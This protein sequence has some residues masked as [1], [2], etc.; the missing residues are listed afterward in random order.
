MRGGSAPQTVEAGT[1]VRVG[2][3]SAVD[4]G[5][6]PGREYSYALFTRRKG[7]WAGPV[8]LT[9]GT[10]SKPGAAVAVAAYATPAST[11]IVHAG[12]Q[13]VPHLIDGI[14]TVTLPSGQ[15]TPV[16]GT[17]FVLPIST[18]LSGGFLGTVTS[19]SANGRAVT[20]TPAG[21]ADVFTQYDLN[22][23]LP[24]SDPQLAVP[25]SEI[26]NGRSGRASS[27]SRG[28]SRKGD[29][30]SKF[31]LNPSL[32]FGGSKLA[33]SLL[34]KR[35]GGIPKGAKFSFN[36]SAK[37]SIAPVISTESTSA[38]KCHL[39]FRKM[40]WN[41][42]THPVPMSMVF[43]PG[44]QIDIDGK[45]GIDGVD[46][47]MTLK[48][49]ADGTFGSSNSFKAQRPSV[50]AAVDRSLAANSAGTIS[51]TL[52]GE[53]TVGPGAG[54][55]AAGVIAGVSGQLKPVIA[56]F[57]ITAATSG[58]GA[59][60]AT[61][62]GGEASLRLIAK[63]WLG[64]FSRSRSFRLHTEPWDYTH[65]TYLYLPAGCE[66]EGDSS[67]TG[68]RGGTGRRSRSSGPDPGAELKQVRRRDPRVRDPP[69][70]QQLAQMPG[71]S[72]IGLR[73]LLLATQRAGPGRLR[74]MHLRADTLELIDDEPPARGG[75]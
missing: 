39:P 9:A 57:G 34:T 56:D 62:L 8:T 31:D 6:A 59:C 23:T 20:L 73:S 54:T 46:A 17:G 3:G 60:L 37:L 71:I 42:P 21:L 38:I 10:A 13:F 49:G 24:K 5:L 7:Q 67:G 55:H 26:S 63:A 65:T 14:V 70:Q 47:S 64:R 69:D 51:A 48:F 68:G 4:A 16:L 36:A 19:I 44:A 2:N 61:R 66:N 18:T 33:V 12:G 50:S 45:A 30:G 74:Q 32:S 29:G 53:F 72:E 27:R 43:A 28:C 35:K 40:I 41:L 1:A 75:L 11:V 25:N 22:V 52:G 15:P 58:S